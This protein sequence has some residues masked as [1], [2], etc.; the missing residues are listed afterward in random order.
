MKRTYLCLPLIAV[1]S[2][3]QAQL[4]S[5]TIAA[6][7]NATVQPGGPRSGSSGK[8]FFN[9]EGSDN[10]NFASYGVVDFDGTGVSFAGPI[11]A[12][13]GVKLFLTQSNAGFSTSGPVRVYLTPD[14]ATDIQPGTSPLV[15]DPSN[16]PG[17]IAS[18]AFSALYDLGVGNYV[19]GTSGDVDVFSFSVSGAAST[20]LG[21]SLGA[22]GSSV[23]FVLAGDAGSTAATYAG[24]SNTTFTG[25][26]AQFEAEAVPEPATLAILGLGSLIALRSRR[27]NS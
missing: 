18:G 26:Q 8:A 2:L 27:K 21:S 1:A 5:N 10:G 9:I 6:F 23:R 22:G 15:F 20:L 11:G 24:F 13:T 16:P 3:S 25:P 19:V 4:M 14:T 7:D 12:I 17:G